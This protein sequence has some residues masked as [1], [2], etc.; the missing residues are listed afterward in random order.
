MHK[1]D[2]VQ[3]LS[4]TDYERADQAISPYINLNTLEVTGES[5][6]LSQVGLRWDS[7]QGT[8]GPP[9]DSTQEYVIQMGDTLST[10]ADR[11][12]L[13]SGSLVLANPDLKD[14]ELI[15]PGQVLTIPAQAFSESELAIEW[16]AREKKLTASGGLTKAG[17]FPSKRNFRVPVGYSYKSRGFH[18]PGH[19]GDDLVAAAGTPIYAS[20]AGQIISTDYGYNGGYGNL[21]KIDHGSGVTTRYGHLSA[22]TKGVVGGAWVV[23]GQLIGYVG[24]TGNSTGAHLHFEIR[25]NGV[26]VD[27]GM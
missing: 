15:H 2:R 21:I 4:G 12:G 25:V 11:Y 6:R 1:L 26:A 5:N 23:R 27:P 13:S 16:D 8:G 22:F 18:P 19:Y 24:S 20:E 3:A 7:N 10:I 17:S 9:S 14:T